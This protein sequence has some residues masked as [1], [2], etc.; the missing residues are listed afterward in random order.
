MVETKWFRRKVVRGENYARFYV[1]RRR[2]SL[3]CLVVYCTTA[4]LYWSEPPFEMQLSTVCSAAP[5][6]DC[7]G[8]ILLSVLMPRAVRCKA[9]LVGQTFHD[10]FDPRDEAADA[11]FPPES[12]R[13]L[14]ARIWWLIR[15]SHT[16]PRGRKD[17]VPL[18]QF[19]SVLGQFWQS[20]L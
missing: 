9:Y 1:R 6:D 11:R 18:A 10:W 8:C 14:L 12:W 13:L 20:M 19:S 16:I 2:T 15:Q 4:P 3:P 5:I 7:T 17:G